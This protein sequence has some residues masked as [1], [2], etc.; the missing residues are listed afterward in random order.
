MNQLNPFVVKSFSDYNLPKTNNPDGSFTLGQVP[1]NVK[2]ENDSANE[3]VEKEVNNGQVE[4]G[5]NKAENEPD[6]FV[7]PTD[8]N[9]PNADVKKGGVSKTDSDWT[10]N[11]AK[12]ST[13]TSKTDSEPITR[14]NKT[15]REVKMPVVLTKPEQETVKMV[16][17]IYKKP[18]TQLSQ[19]EKALKAELIKLEQHNGEHIAL[20]KDSELAKLHEKHGVRLPQVLSATEQF[21]EYAFSNV[22]EF[23]KDNG[24]VTTKNDNIFV[25]EN[26][27]Y[28]NKKGQNLN[29]V[30]SGGAKYVELKE[31]DKTTLVPIEGL[32][33]ENNVKTKFALTKNNKS[34]L[35]K[36]RSD[37]M[38]ELS[39]NKAEIAKANE[40]IT[41]G[42]LGQQ[43]K[44]FA[45]IKKDT[46][47]AYRSTQSKD[48]GVRKKGKSL[49]S[50]INEILGVV[51]V[52]ASAITGGQRHTRIDRAGG[53]Y[54]Q[55]GGNYY[56][57]NSNYSSIRYN[58]F[59]KSLAH[60]DQSLRNPNQAV[61]DGKV[62]SYKILREQ[63][64][65]SET[66]IARMNPGK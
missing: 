8:E 35:A 34:L 60:H 5:S 27:T 21:S 50:T 12:S 37:L 38:S 25:S 18:E 56:G 40:M 19:T 22:E 15:E 29:L 48:P 7:T 14:A 42:E 61:L 47:Y 65:N 64:A 52:V 6:T 62:A 9:K 26:G 36:G 41:E 30:E 16:D 2:V 11:G 33:D 58:A 51:T 54:H 31:G 20:G 39:A 66:A 28:Q 10:E 49:L 23:I 53:G 32:I 63:Y 45:Q 43:K 24:R 3:T 55:S 13:E 1:N 46:E 59:N 57:H 4:F 44:A 17:S